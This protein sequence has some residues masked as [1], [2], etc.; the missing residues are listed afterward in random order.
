MEINTFRQTIADL[1][2]VSSKVVRCTFVVNSP[3]S[4]YFTLDLR[5]SYDEI[6]LMNLA[7]GCTVLASFITQSKCIDTA[8]D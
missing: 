3:Y 4:H 1:G 8:V 2:L 5:S 6:C 7:P